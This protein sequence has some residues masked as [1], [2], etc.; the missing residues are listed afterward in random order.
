MDQIGRLGHPR[1]IILTLQKGGMEG[2]KHTIYLTH[3]ISQTNASQSGPHAPMPALLASEQGSELVG[4]IL[5]H[6]NWWRP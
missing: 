2:A 3:S 5:G 6:H 1:E 4:R